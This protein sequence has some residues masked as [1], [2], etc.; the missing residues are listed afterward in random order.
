MVCMHAHSLILLDIDIVFAGQGQGEH[1]KDDGVDVYQYFN[2]C[3][4]SGYAD[5]EEV[6]Y[7]LLTLNFF[8]QIM[9]SFK[10]VSGYVCITNKTGIGGL[11]DWL[12]LVAHIM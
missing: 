5:D 4:Y 6:F 1:Y 7:L 12:V 8:T 11:G 3:C 10:N 9:F 2:T